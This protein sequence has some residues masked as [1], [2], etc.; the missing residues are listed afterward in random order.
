MAHNNWHGEMEYLDNDQDGVPDTKLTH[1]SV[2]ARYH[3]GH[4][5]TNCDE[6]PQQLLGSVPTEVHAQNYQNLYTTSP[7]NRA[8]YRT[9]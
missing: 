1:V 5:L 2:H 9:N 8:I 4:S 7:T 6:Y 3:V